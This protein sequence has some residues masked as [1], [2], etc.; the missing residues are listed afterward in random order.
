MCAAAHL[1]LTIGVYRPR[2]PDPTPSKPTRH[3]DASRPA[4]TRLPDNLVSGEA[5]PTHL[6]SELRTSPGY[7]TCPLHWPVSLGLSVKP[8]PIAVSTPH[9]VATCAGEEGPEASVSPWASASVAGETSMGVS[10][11]FVRLW[12]TAWRR[13]HFRA[14]QV[15]PWHDDSDVVCAHDI[16][17]L[18]SPLVGRSA[19]PKWCRLHGAL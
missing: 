13:L 19:G 7:F 2:T 11:R 10:R 1:T 5:V 17:A 15:R 6:R 3:L 14:L 18:P 12:K 16:W 9:R 8:W 4:V